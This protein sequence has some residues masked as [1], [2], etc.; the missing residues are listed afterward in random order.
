ME[1]VKKGIILNA[2]G[3]F[4]Y[5]DTGDCVAECRARGKFRF[6]KIMPVAGD[7][8]EILIGK[9]KKGVVTGIGERKNV[10]IRPAIANVDR[11]FIVC[12]KAPPETDLFLIDKIAVLSES[13]GAEPVIVV[14]KND[15]DKGQE[16]CSVYEKAGYL[17]IPV[18]SVTGYGFDR[19]KSAIGSGISVFTGNS[20]VGK[21]SI[22]NRVLEG[23]TLETGGIS[24]RIG[25]G[26]HTT[27]QVKLFKVSDN[28]YVAD[29]PGFSSFDLTRMECMSYKDVAGSF[30]EFREFL[31]KC[32][33]TGCSHT[34]EDGCEII[35]QTE[36]GAISASRFESYVKI[37]ESLKKIKDY[38]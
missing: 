1:E 18:S 29:T 30:R 17:T 13:V 20:G 7:S 9:N 34:K 32:R 3:G 25:R 4:Y 8:A 11:M 35:R 27:R 21:S 37:F 2:I 19:L 31:G 5:V 26:K 23:I 22:L 36:L 12:S 16:L 14:N 28:S 33:Y 6:D 24:E 10:F 38:N 15:L